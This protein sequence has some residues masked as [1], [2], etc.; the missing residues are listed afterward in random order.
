MGFSITAM[1]N[2][3]RLPSRCSLQFQI[4][5]FISLVIMHRTFHST[6][7]ATNALG[8]RRAIRGLWFLLLLALATQSFSNFARADNFSLAGTGVVTMTQSGWY[9]QQVNKSS[10]GTLHFTVTKTGAYS[11]SL[12]MTQFIMTDSSASIVFGI[13][14]KANSTNSDTAVISVTDGSSTHSVTIIAQ[15]LGFV[16]PTKD[17]LVHANTLIMMPP[18]IIADTKTATTLIENLW[19]SDITVSATVLSGNGFALNT[20][21]LMIHPDT[22]TRYSGENLSITYTRTGHAHDT[23]RVQVSCTSPVTQ[24]DTIYYVSS[25]SQVIVAHAKLHGD[26]LNLSGVLAGDTTC[27]IVVLKNDDSTSVTITT[28]AIQG[29]FFSFTKPTLPLTLAGNS[30]LTIPACFMPGFPRQFTTGYLTVGYTDN[31]GA[32]GTV[33]LLINGTS[34]NCLSTLPDSSLYFEDVIA[35]GSVIGDV[36]LTNNTKQSLTFTPTFTKSGQPFEFSPNPFPLTLASKTSATVHCKFSPT[37]VGTRYYNGIVFNTDS[38][39]SACTGKAVYVYGGKVLSGT[40]T[41]ALDLFPSQS[42][43]LALTGQSQKITKTFTFRNN[44][45]TDIKVDTAYITTGTHVRIVS[46]NPS[47]VPFTLAA[48]HFMTI[49]VECDADTLGYYSDELTIITDHT[50]LSQTFKIEAVR[51]TLSAVHSAQVGATNLELLA[52][53]NPSHGPIT[54]EL[55]GVSRANI[56]IMDLL[57]NVI[58]RSNGLAH[59][60]WNG[61]AN[62]GAASTGVYFARATGVDA[63]GVLF[64]V[65]KRIVMEH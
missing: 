13:I 9:N 6:K 46:M 19:A 51:H 4:Y 61:A 17:F 35:G 47:T 63:H 38:G 12:Q 16:P 59:W 62:S 20:T 11:I 18:L 60:S 48:G 7:R 26:P 24:I 28:M 42:E 39:L 52:S 8:E 58:A 14:F 40:D 10:S 5:T 56:E 65:T 37:V 21:S 1:S 53:P 50:L 3:A 43:I 55:K 54:L 34:L 64:T 25:D 27:G 49:D 45:T 36:T 30:S 22:L 29:Y 41:S 57:G 31:H 44:L 32:G 33:V 15:A 23:A 2:E